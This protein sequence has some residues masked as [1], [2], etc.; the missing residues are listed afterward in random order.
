MNYEDPLLASLTSQDFK[1]AFYRGFKFLPYQDYSGANLYNLNDMVNYK[2]NNIYSVYK[3]LISNNTSLPTDA[4]NWQIQT[5]INVLDY[6]IND[7]IINAFDGAYLNFRYSLFQ[8]DDLKKKA[9]LLLSAHYLFNQIKEN[10]FSGLI[11]SSASADSVSESYTV[12]QWMQDYKYN[13][14]TSS[15]YGIQYLQLIKPLEML[16]SFDWIDG[17]YS[18][19]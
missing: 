13:F 2:N 4:N 8:N 12:P 15:K 7:D 18:F 14:F 10:G 6:V 9:F 17:D 19:N 11:L 3:S 16:S 5:N 1:N